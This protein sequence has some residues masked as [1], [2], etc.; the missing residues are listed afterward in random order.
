[1]IQ[2]R[3]LFI[4]SYAKTNTIQRRDILYALVNN[5]VNKDLINNNGKRN[6]SM[7]EQKLKLK[8]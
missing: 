2:K 4:N 6:I 8:I 7:L 1:M 3:R 5:L